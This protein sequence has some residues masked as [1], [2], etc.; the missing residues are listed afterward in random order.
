M[1]KE[2]QDICDEHGINRQ[3]TVRNRPQ[4]NGVA[5]RFNCVLSEGITA[6]LFE[7]GLPPTFWGEALSS[8]VHVL[9][10]NAVRPLHSSTQRPM[11]PSMARSLMSPICAFGA[12]W[13]ICMCKRT[14]VVR[15]AL[16]WRSASSLGIHLITRAGSST[17]PSPSAQLS[18]NVLS[19]MRD[20]SL[21]S[22]TGH[23]SQLIALTL[24]PHLSLS[25]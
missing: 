18:L 2:L 25:F 6:M 23:L 9:N 15:C 14:S 13:L 11:R 20:T 19:S 22:R 17:I 10:S 16:T 12:A 5:E 8:L 1:S 24:P 3:H 4:Q 7:A 21:D